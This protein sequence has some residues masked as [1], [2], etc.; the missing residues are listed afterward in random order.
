MLQYSISHCFLY[1]YVIPFLSVLLSFFPSLLRPL[2][3]LSSS[4]FCFLF[5]WFILPQFLLGLFNFYLHTISFIRDSLLRR[6]CFL[7]F[8]GHADLYL[9]TFASQLGYFHF[10]FFSQHLCTLL[11][12]FSL[13]CYGLP[14]LS[15]SFCLSALFFFTLSLYLIS[16]FFKRMFRPVSDFLNLF[17]TS[18]LSVSFL[19]FPHAP[20]V[21]K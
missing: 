19:S 4:I 10:W 12:L 9:G 14:S 3:S 5:P 15:M 20:K 8:L 18:L 16:N 6:K 11:S 2:F 7:M 21:V 17:L 13:P 1:N